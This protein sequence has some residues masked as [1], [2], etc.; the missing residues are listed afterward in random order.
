[1]MAGQTLIREF[2]ACV[3]KDHGLA[4][5]SFED[6]HRWSVDRPADFWEAL[7]C[8]DGI[9]SR[10]P[11]SEVLTQDRMPNA[12]W[13]VGAEVNYARQVFRH[14]DAAEAEEQP[15]IIAEDEG[16][17]VISLGWHEL[18]RRSFS[19]AC[20]FRRLGLVPGDRVAAYLPN[21]I[22]AVIAFLACASIGA[23]WT[24]CAPDMG[25]RAIIDRF[26]QIEPKLLIATDGVFYAGKGR[27]LADTV[28]SIGASLLTLEQV[29][30]V[31][32]GHSRGHIGHTLDFA[33][34]INRDDDEIRLF[35]PSWL[36]FDHP[37][38]ILYSSG[39]T[40]KPKAIVHG[41]GG[42]VLNAAAMRLHMDLRPSYGAGARP[43]RFHWFSSTGWMVWN[44]QVGGLLSGTTICL[45][46]G[47]PSGPKERVDWSTLWRFVARH[48]ISFF[49]S[50]AQFFTMCLRSGIDFSVVGD[51]SSLRTI[52]ST[53]S[54]LPAEVQ[55][56]LS[57]RLALSAQV[58]PFWLNSSGGT[59]ICGVF[60]S[61]NRDLPPAPGRMQ[62]RQ[63]GAAVEAWSPDGKPLVGD[64]GELVCVRPMPSMPLYFWGDLDGSRYRDSY[65]GMFPGVWRH[66]DWIR[67]DADGSC[68]IS[69]RSD[70][71]INRG[72][73]RMGT[74]EIYDAIE[75]VD[76]VGDSLV[77]DVRAGAGESE[78]LAFIVPAAPAP[79]PELTTRI[80]QAIRTSLSPRFIPDHV[81]IVPA[82]PRTL[83][84]K[85]QELPIKHLFEGRL[86]SEVIDL[87]AMANPE[88]LGDYVELADA[89]R[90]MRKEAG[91][92][93]RAA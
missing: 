33:D 26:S 74:S 45:Y 51:L 68:E 31:R 49:G 46:D 63:L 5:A 56:E 2:E 77:I 30:L 3:A 60:C 1:M 34:L 90:A 35:E 24:V 21:R 27:D 22:E 83:S 91:E 85:K 87:A 59:D 39:T 48:G 52:G 32:S 76:G 6:L 18:R 93:D 44:A 67:I 88:C 15:A 69:G 70:A 50:G 78:L 61:G 86:L 25:M 13:F 19:L 54:P 4:F 72:G 57:E 12:R 73:H 10:T 64:V 79:Q 53:A 28:R 20:E 14:A 82:I 89:F 7:W 71:T 42:I 38:W 37:L 41:H 81:Y 84:M 58:E 8:F 36:P 17:A 55:L 66:G 62:C 75:S 65:F 16:G 43:E 9:L 23:I 92:P 11:Y 40:G 47:S 80:A 29:V